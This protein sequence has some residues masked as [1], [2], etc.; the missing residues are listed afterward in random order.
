MSPTY[1]GR[2][3]RHRLTQ[4]CG[5]CEHLSPTHSLSQALT[6]G[7]PAMLELSSTSQASRRLSAIVGDENSLCEHHRRKQRSSLRRFDPYL[8]VKWLKIA[9]F[10]LHFEQI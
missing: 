2:S 5:I 3:R 8:E 1:L 6:A 9:Q 7:L 10:D 4:R